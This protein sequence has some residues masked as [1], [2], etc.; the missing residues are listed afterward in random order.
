M[1][2]FSSEGRV[3]IYF[4]PTIANKAAPTVAELNAGTA[5]TL[6]V[7]RDGFAPSTTQNMV[8]TSSL[9]DIFDTQA[10]GTEGGPITLTGF[11]DDVPA[12]DTM[13]NLFT[14][15][16]TGYVVVREGPAETVAWTAAQK[17]QVYPIQSHHP[18]PSQTAANAARTFTVM[19]AVTS[20]PDRKATVA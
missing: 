19:V 4:V 16:L 12:N 1:T 18:I 17:A 7:P 3:R 10:T 15:G 14:N 6:F 5:L 11:R 8:D 13:W 20:A 2:K 9:A